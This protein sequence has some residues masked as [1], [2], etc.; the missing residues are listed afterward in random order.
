M[1][2]LIICQNRHEQIAIRW[3]GER[4]AIVSHNRNPLHPKV[5]V[6]NSKEGQLLSEFISKEVSQC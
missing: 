5:I 2:Q 1:K 3:D 4:F 6:L